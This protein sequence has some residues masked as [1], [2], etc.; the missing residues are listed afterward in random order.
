MPGLSP[1]YYRDSRGRQPVKAFISSLETAHQVAID[2]FILRV[3][4]ICT[5]QHP[6]L[7]YPLSTSVDGS[8]RELRCHAGAQLYRILYRRSGNLLI[9]LH[10]IK[11]NRGDIPQ[12]DIDRANRRWAD[13]KK[14]MDARP[15]KPPRA[16]G[17][18][19]P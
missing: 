3:P 13:F 11:K 9:L 14:R 8:L 1:V 15:R 4:E 16:A 17:Q 2:N 12:P 19:A 10:A 7:P 5:P 6:D 18:D